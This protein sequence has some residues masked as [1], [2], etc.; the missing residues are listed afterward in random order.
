M[1][2]V[3]YKVLAAGELAELLRGG[4]RGT[5]LDRQDGFIHLSAAGQL[6]E[7][8]D[9]HFAGSTDLVVA[10]IDLAALGGA[11]RWKVSRGGALF[12]HLYGELPA[13]AVLA[14]APLGR[15]ATGEVRRPA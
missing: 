8:V 1:D 13:A 4:W 3:A 15:D 7:T 14:H 2:N 12:P 6:T 5:A 10:A 11:V 9:T